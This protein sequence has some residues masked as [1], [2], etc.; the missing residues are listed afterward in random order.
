L[1]SRVVVALLEA[2]AAL[3]RAESGPNPTRHSRDWALTDEKIRD[4][5]SDLDEVPR[6]T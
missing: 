4:R 2:V 1:C 3:P 5:S 6:H